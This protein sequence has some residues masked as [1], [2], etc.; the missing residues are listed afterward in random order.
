[1]KSDLHDKY[2]KSLI[3]YYQYLLEYILNNRS[4]QVMSLT[5]RVDKLTNKIIDDFGD[6]LQT[7]L[8]AQIPEISQIYKQSLV[9]INTVRPDRPLII[10]TDTIKYGRTLNKTLKVIER[11]FKPDKTWIDN[12]IIYDYVQKSVGTTLLISRFLNKNKKF[13]GEAIM[14]TQVKYNI[15]FDSKTLKISRKSGTAIGRDLVTF[16]LILG[17][18]QHIGIYNIKGTLLVMS[19]GRDKNGYMTVSY[20]VSN[21]AVKRTIWV[22]D[23]YSQVGSISFLTYNHA[24]NIP[25][26]IQQIQGMTILNINN[27]AFIDLDNVRY[28]HECEDKHDEMLI[29]T[30]IQESIQDVTKE[31]YGYPIQKHGSIDRITVKNTRDIQA[32][33]M[34]PAKIRETNKLVYER[35]LENLQN[36]KSWYDI[37]ST[38]KIEMY[39]TEKDEQKILVF[40]GYCRGIYNNILTATI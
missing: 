33:M 34:K 13:M 29:E 32:I 12:L 1:M 40:N 2:K 30:G 27:K 25:L 9:T 31:S 35:T 6:E 36:I 28:V 16:R 18:S 24:H 22:K 21:L 37:D 3:S 17:I 26:M 20:Y 5:D 4:I 15:E 7:K 8:K 39:K 38:N 14:A 11:K 23:E 10:V 19:M